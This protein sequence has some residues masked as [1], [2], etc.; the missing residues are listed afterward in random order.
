LRRAKKILVVD[1][2]PLIRQVFRILLRVDGH[3]MEEAQ[4]GQEALTVFDMRKF[5]LVFID[6]ALPGMDGHELARSIR[7][8]NA[9]LPVVMVTDVPLKAPMAGVSRIITKPFDAGEIRRT[10]AK[11][12]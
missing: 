2:E 1:D 7:A 10:I 8:R 9:D 5:D 6:F 11:F 4:S 3:A 12:V